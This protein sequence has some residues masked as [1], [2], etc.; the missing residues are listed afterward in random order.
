MTTCAVVKKIPTKPSSL[1]PTSIPTRFGRLFT[2]AVDGYTYAQPLYVANVVITNN[3][4]HNGTHNVVF[5]ATENDTV[6]AFDADNNAG[7]NSTAL[8][9]DEDLFGRR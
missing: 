8:L 2:Q 5:V 4:I 3:G 6:Y 9:A 7:A 1:P